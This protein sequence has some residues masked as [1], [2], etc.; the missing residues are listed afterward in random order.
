[1]N[2]GISEEQM[3]KK[4]KTLVNWEGVHMLAREVGA[5]E[6]ARRLG[7]NESTVL[8]RAKREDWKLPKRKGGA[9]IKKANAITMQSTPSEALIAVHA[10]LEEVTKTGLKQTLAKA[11]QALAKKEALPVESIAQFKDACLA[12]AKLFGWD[13]K[14]QTSVTVNTAIQAGIVCDEATRQE[15]IAMRERLLEQQTAEQTHKFKAA[16]PAP[17]PAPEI[18]SNGTTDTGKAV[19]SP[20]PPHVVQRDPYLAEMESIGNAASWKHGKGSEP[21]NYAGSFGPWP[22][23]VS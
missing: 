2:N 23:G 8:S 20:A 19:V 18:L 15:L 12:G 16:T 3:Q 21:E 4:N 6:A 17:L 22:E 1:M 7:I 10:D 13:G 14:E 5:R 11:V 9:S